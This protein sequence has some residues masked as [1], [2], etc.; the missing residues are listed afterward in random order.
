M[1]LPFRDVR[2]RIPASVAFRLTVLLLALGAVA[3]AQN[4]PS[5]PAEPTPTPEPAPVESSS[6]RPNAA[7]YSVSGLVLNSVT[8]EPV[9][10]ALVQVAGPALDTTTPLALLTDSEGRFNF[11]DLPESDITL[12][13]RKPG[14][15]NDQELHPENFQPAIVHIGTNTPSMVLK[16]L[17]EC[18]I[19]G[20]VVTTTGE[21]L[22]DTPV[23]VFF[24]RVVDGRKHWELRNQTTADE[25]G[26][27]RVAGLNPGRYLLVAGPNLSLAAPSIPG[28]HTVRE[29]GFGPLLFPGVSELDSATLISAAPGQQTQA[30]FSVKPEPVFK[31]AGTISGAAGMNGN[32][33]FRTRSGESLNW[34]GNFDPQSGK[35]DSRVAAGS[36]ILSFR[37]PDA[38][39]LVTAAD[40]PVNVSSNV[41]GITLVPSSAPLLPVHIEQRS[42]T[43]LGQDSSISNTVQL[44]EQPRIP[45]QVTF[46]GPQLPCP[47]VRL[48]PTEA[49]LEEEPLQAGLVDNRP[50]TFAVRNLVAGRY[51]VEILCNPPWYVQSASSGNTDVLREDLVITAGRRPDALEVVVRDD[52]TMLRGSLRADSEPVRGNVLLIPEQASLTQIKLTMAAPTGEFGFIGIAPG[53]YKLLGFDSV[54]GLEFRNPDVLA[55]YLSH[56]VRITVQPHEQ[57]S[58]TVE[59]I[60]VG[61]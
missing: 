44:G 11:P 25:D 14:F 54:D 49:H 23:R 60:S 7:T 1:R 8:G 46:I 42:S 61:K 56:A 48:L 6:A 55:P 9:R 28:V 21:P 47:Q 59:R 52:G 27:F 16:L 45:D 57:A 43:S 39:G 20:H 50:S 13:A 33:Q 12:A 30:D 19:W 4:G 38:T 26:Q 29:E 24:E 40:V 15:F 32:L 58:A 41:T 34:S 22:E 17:P 53:D 37:A 5:E 2:P 36:Y 31:I 10:R 18:T 35:F 51:S 3:V